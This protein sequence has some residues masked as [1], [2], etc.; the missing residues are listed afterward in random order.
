MR[1]AIFLANAAEDQEVSMDLYNDATE[2]QLLCT[3]TGKSISIP[4]PIYF[5]ADQ[6]TATTPTS[7]S[8]SE[9]LISYTQRQPTNIEPTAAATTATATTTG[10]KVHCSNTSLSVLLDS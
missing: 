8:S 5:I 2:L 6:S 10:K 1:S 4:N 3:S 9:L 7:T